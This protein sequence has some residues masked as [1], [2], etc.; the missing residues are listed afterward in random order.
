MASICTSMPVLALNSGSK[1]W[2]KCV[3]GTFSIRML[4]VWAWALVAKPSAT[5]PASSSLFIG[6]SPSVYWRS[7]WLLGELPPGASSLQRPQRQP[8]DQVAAHERQQHHHG[9]DRHQRAGGHQRDVDAA[10]GLESREA[11]RQ[12]VRRLAREDQG[13]KEFIPAEDER[14]QAGRQEPRR[15]HRHGDAQEGL[16]ARS[17]VHPRRLL[18]LLDVAL[19][20]GDEHPGEKRDADGEVRD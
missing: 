5:A 8:L 19:E 17:A 18:Q 1:S 4:M 9:Q 12:S 7:I 20:E 14:Q 3:S 15:R 13:E 11:D 6:V 2:T 10:L 16:E